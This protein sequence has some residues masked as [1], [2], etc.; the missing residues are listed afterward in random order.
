MQGGA[1]PLDGTFAL[2][3]KFDYFQAKW[4]PDGMLFRPLGRPEDATNFATSS[5]LVSVSAHQ[6]ALVEPGR[7]LTTWDDRDPSVAGKNTSVFYTTHFA[8]EPLREIM[9]LGVMQAGIG[10]IRWAG[11]QR[12]GDSLSP[13]PVNIGTGADGPSPANAGSISW[14]G[15]RFRTECEV[16]SERWVITGELVP[17]GDAPPRAMRV[18]YATPQLTNNYVIRYG[19]TPA[20]KYPYLPAAI[21]N[22]WVTKSPGGVE[23]EIDLDEWQILDLDL[24]EAPLAAQIFDLAPFLGQGQLTPHVYTN[25]ALYD[26]QPNGSLQLAVPLTPPKNVSLP[27]LRSSPRVFYACWAGLNLAIFALLLGAKRAK[28]QTKTEN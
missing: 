3:T 28:N 21:T 8:L 24:A 19:Y 10:T 16:D 13:Q 18:C 26:R 7:R 23:K 2:S 25:G 9:S 27:R 17:S 15:N 14:T 6:H 5:L 12:G 22:F 20:L 11:G 1:R 4:Q